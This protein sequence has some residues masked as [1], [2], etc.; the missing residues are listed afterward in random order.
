MSAAWHI[1]KIVGIFKRHVSPG[2]RARI[3]QNE[4]ETK[5]CYCHWCKRRLVS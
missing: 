4:C 1:I 5:Y 2:P 3:D